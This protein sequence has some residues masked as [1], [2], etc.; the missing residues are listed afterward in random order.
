MA[1]RARA[2][3]Q[4]YFRFCSHW[5]WTSSFAVCYFKGSCADLF[6]QKVLENKDEID[7]TR[8]VCFASFGGWYC[9]WFQHFVYNLTYTRLYGAGTS[10]TVVAKKLATDH[11]IHVPLVSLFS[12]YM[13]QECLLIPLKKKHENGDE[14]TEWPRFEFTLLTDAAKRWRSEALDVMKA[15]WIVWTPAHIVT[16]KFAPEPLRITWIATVSG[17]WLVILS[18]LTH[19][20]FKENHDGSKGKDM[21][22]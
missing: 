6:T 22:G 4:A 11:F 17:G 8:N 16:F 14:H 15:Y 13:W 3:G 20:V 10:M 1:S 7:V 21:S 18:L 9:G 19:Q 5:P 2:F 12:Y